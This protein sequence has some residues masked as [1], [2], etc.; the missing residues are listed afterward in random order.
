MIPQ[1]RIDLVRAEYLDDVGGLALGTFRESKVKQGVAAAIP[2]VPVQVRGGCFI[3]RIL[4]QKK[5]QHSKL[6][7]YT[8]KN[9]MANSMAD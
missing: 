9:Q 2:S 1:P 4:G 3:V 7:V 6:A 5:L 8:N